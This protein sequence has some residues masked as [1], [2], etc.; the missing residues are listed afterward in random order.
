MNAPDEETAVKRLR[1]WWLSPPRTGM[2]RIIIPWEY[3]H[4]RG[5]GITRLLAGA[6][7]AAAGVV[8]LAYGAYGWGAFFLL[9]AVLAIACGWWYL[10]IART[11][12]ART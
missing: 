10:A 7:A 2:Q 4:L 6:V 11:P 9:V 3:R 8:C 12:S 1:R 5:F